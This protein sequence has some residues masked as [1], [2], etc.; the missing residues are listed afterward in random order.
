MVRFHIIH[1]YNQYIRCQY[2]KLWNYFF[3]WAVGVDCSNHFG[4]CISHLGKYTNKK[5]R[6]L[7]LFIFFI[8][9]R[10][11]V[12]VLALDRAEIQ[13]IYVFAFCILALRNNIYRINLCLVWYDTLVRCWT[14]WIA[15]VPLSRW[16]QTENTA[17]TAMS[18]IK[19]THTHTHFRLWFIAI[20]P[21][22]FA[23]VSTRYWWHVRNCILCAFSTHSLFIKFSPIF[24]NASWWFYY[25]L[26]QKTEQW[27]NVWE[28]WFR[29]VALL[30]K[31]TPF[32]RHNCGNSKILHTNWCSA[33][34]PWILS[35][36]AC[37]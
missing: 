21:M 7:F 30:S 35:T 5:L 33:Y 4:C 25:Y 1:H 37:K 28:S 24:I 29:T 10:W 16:R 11:C 22:L 20:E 34:K 19:T 8:D 15:I 13:Q 14:I 27:A 12:R 6:F 9:N 23:C 32:H 2:R 3:L 36:Q 18:S 26:V 31:I 17:F